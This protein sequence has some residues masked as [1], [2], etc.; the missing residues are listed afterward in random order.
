MIGSADS[1]EHCEEVAKKKGPGDRNQQYKS[2]K[3]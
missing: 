1:E 2:M 3:F